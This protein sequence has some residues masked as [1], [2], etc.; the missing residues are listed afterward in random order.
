MRLT[1]PLTG[2]SKKWTLSKRRC[3][4]IFQDSRSRR[5]RRGR[6]G[7]PAKPSR[8][9]LR[10]VR[11]PLDGRH[12]I[13]SGG[14]LGAFTA[15]VGSEDSATLH[16]VRRVI[17]AL[18]CSSAGATVLIGVDDVHL[19]A[20]RLDVHAKSPS[21]AR[22]ACSNGSGDDA[23]PP[24]LHEI[25]R[26][27]GF[28]CLDLQPLSRDETAKLLSAALGGAVVDAVGRLWKLTGGNSLYLPYRRA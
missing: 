20:R 26:V 1:W 14:A 9:P 11:H 18:T 13:G 21:G 22:R 3:R 4:P 8:S 24:T 17:E 10:R 7:L 15:W 6:A 12:L 2:R 19:I 25:W 28:D 5:R 16:L 23:V 27:G